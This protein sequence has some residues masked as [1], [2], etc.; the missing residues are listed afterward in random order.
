M[1]VVHEV[2]Y[3]ATGFRGYVLS[4]VHSD[5]EGTALLT[6][7]AG[8]YVSAAMPSRCRVCTNKDSVRSEAAF[9]GLRDQ[10]V[11]V[12]RRTEN[13]PGLHPVITHQ[14]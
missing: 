12:A 8:H 7:Y 6:G 11:S 3:S 4:Q 13:A 1:C 14:L 10:A 2:P 9:S 5:Y